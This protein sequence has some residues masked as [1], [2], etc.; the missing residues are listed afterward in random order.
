V[1]ASVAKAHIDSIKSTDP[2]IVE[3]LK[4]F[5]KGGKKK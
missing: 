3:F 1:A 4:D 2:K 5:A